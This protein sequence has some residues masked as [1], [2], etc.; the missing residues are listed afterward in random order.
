MVFPDPLLPADLRSVWQ[1]WLGIPLRWLFNAATTSLAAWLGSIPLIACYFHLITPIGLLANLVIVP[2]SS[3]ALACNMASLA[4]SALVPAAAELFN[5]AA[6]F[7][8]WLMVRL[9]EW[10]AQAPG[11]CFHIAAPSPAGFALYYALL[12]NNHFL[13]FFF[14]LRC[15]AY[16]AVYY[17]FRNFQNDLF[18]DE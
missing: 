12:A 13:D 16:Q 5:H 10:A 18:C 15:F 2:L 4:V 8:M 11:G 1:R 9:S 17:V 7:F 6:W 14:K 3:V